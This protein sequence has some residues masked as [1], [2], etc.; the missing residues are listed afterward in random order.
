MA[1]TA[2]VVMEAM[3]Q[4]APSHLAM[5]WDSVGLQI[6]SPDG[7]IERIYVALDL[8]EATLQ[9][10]VE[11]SA[12]MI[13]THH[14]FL[15]SPINKIDTSEPVG[16]IIK[17]LLKRDMHL[18]SAHTNMDIAKEGLNDWTARKLGLENI[19]VLE[20][21]DFESLYKIIVFVP[22]SHV[23]HVS[24]AMAQAGAGQIGAYSHCS[25]RSRGTGTFLPREG[26][27]PFI[28]QQGKIEYVHEIKIET[29]VPERM[30]AGVVNKMIQAH[31]YE[32]PAYDL[33]LLDNQG[34][35]MGM[36]RWGS[37][38][39]P[40]Q[41]DQLLKQLKKMYQ[42]DT[43]RYVPGKGDSIKQAAVLTGSGASAIRTAWLKGCQALI[44][45]D[46]KYHDAQL[47]EQL[48]IHLFDAGH[49]ETEQCFVTLTA[50]HLRKWQ[51][52]QG[53]CLHIVESSVEKSP[54]KLA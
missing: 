47:A 28:G 10:A 35:T 21:T 50:E 24:D 37:F 7:I 29:I 30:K 13:V 6:G 8:N 43:L 39:L 54:F 2:A 46:V 23:D 14:P 31:P 38:S 16:R 32:E 48:G 4:L 20:T 36:G 42:I 22:E 34:E 1:S 11:T 26:T 19:Q 27:N 15:F 12:N 40:V 41:P 5:E 25:F 3:N 9:E 53:V 49:F 45:G 51:E 52:Q 17:T 33:I 44:T 18:F